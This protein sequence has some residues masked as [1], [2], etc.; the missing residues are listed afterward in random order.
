MANHEQEHHL[1]PARVYFLIW[2]TLIC[3]TGV[4]LGVT[5]LD[6]GKWAIFTAILVASVKA[7]LVTLYFMHLKFERRVIHVILLVTLASFAVFFILVFTDY[8]FR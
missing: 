6:M 5:Y 1:L 8:P 4:T 2:F 7:A 3:L